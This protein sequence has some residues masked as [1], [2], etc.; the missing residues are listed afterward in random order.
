MAD[1]PLHGRKIA[2]LLARADTEQAEF[3]ESRKVLIDAGADIEVISAQAMP[4]RFRT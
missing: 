3:A 4:L 2:I 1:Q